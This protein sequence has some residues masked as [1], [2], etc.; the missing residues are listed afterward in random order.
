M[1]KIIKI[2]PQNKARRQKEERQWNA[3]IDAIIGGR[4][5]PV[6][7]PDFLTEDE[8][9]GV[10]TFADHHQ[11]LIDVLASACEVDGNFSTFSQLIHNKDFRAATDDDHEAVYDYL[12][13]VIDQLKEQGML[14][15]NHLLRKLLKSKLFPFVITTSFSP[16][17]EMVMQDIWK[18]QKIRVLQYRN[19]SSRDLITGIGDIASE[20]DLAIPTV[21]YMFG[22]YSPEPHR[23]VVSDFDMMDFCKSWLTG[24][25]KVPRVLFEA[26]KK[27]YLLVLGNNY[28]DW[29]FRFI[30]YAI[31][32][33]P[34]MM[35][36]SLVLN[37]SLEPSLESFLEQVQTFIERDPKHVIDEIERRI[38]EK[39]KNLM[40][41]EK[42]STPT[43]SSD[44]FI[45]YSRR[46]KELA[47]KLASALQSKELRVW[48]DL[49]DIPGGEDWKNSY[50]KAI[51][52]TRIFIPL[53]SHNIEREYMHPHE[54]RD[55]WLAASA[56]ARKMGGRKFIWPLAEKGF[57]FYNQ[58]TKLPNE[59][60]D[61][62]A[63]WYTIADSLE[64]FASSVKVEVDVLKNKE[65][66]L[67]YGF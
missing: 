40:D 14:R 28:S 27:R 45:S 53:L 38:Q 19:D 34:D 58:D 24:G 47:L 60:T 21:Y 37:N 46:D 55:E 63:S 26:L 43:F 62:N 17:V 65:K 12:A 4:V 29:L 39:R 5:I 18:E 25:N 11:Q 44:V 6:I 36:S 31:R 22:K 41:D 57:D 42:E 32:N 52:E 54:Y 2:N 66:K 9:E 1:T 3:L 30:W 15:P 61:K 33:T 35:R 16:V 48:L 64:D 67:R 56:I 13:Y 23:Y 59:F 49:N 8:K 7:G 20:K 51:R 10:V 50:S